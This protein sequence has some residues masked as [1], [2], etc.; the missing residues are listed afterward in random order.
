MPTPLQ[1]REVSAAAEIA[2][3]FSLVRELRP[4]LVEQTFVQQVLDQSR[5]GYRF[6]LGYAPAP[7][8]MAGYRETS[9]LKRGRH[10]FV[11]DL[12]TAVSERGKGHGKAMLRYL[13]EYAKSRGLEHIYL[14]SRNTAVDFYKSTG[15][16]FLTSI[17]CWIE[18]SKIV[19]N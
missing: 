19:G 17:P 10:L 15:F 3:A 16:T 4:N 5:E 8:V 18:T 14:D 1:I 13:A 12:V 2:A 7:V 11:D 9:T 6:A